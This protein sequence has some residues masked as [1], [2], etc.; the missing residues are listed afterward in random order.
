MD[1]VLT[2]REELVLSYPAK[3]A[4]DRKAGGYVIS[5]PDIPEAVTQAESISEGLEMA[6]D[7]L[8]LVLA[9]YV[10]LGRP[11]PAPSPP[12]RGQRAIRLPGCARA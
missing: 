10:R 1:D 3:F 12:K 2:G 9:E 11:I 5:F 8:E 6:A 7:C 4:P